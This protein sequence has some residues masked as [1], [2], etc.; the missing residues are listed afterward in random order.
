MTL[1]A[2]GSEL[3]LGCDSEAEASSR[4]PILSRD[5]ADLRKQF[6]A[7]N[8]TTSPADTSSKHT[9]RALARCRLVRHVCH[10]ITCTFL[11]DRC[12]FHRLWLL[13]KARQSTA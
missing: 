11:L 12:P 3:E 7:H 13:F 9:L 5:I 8:A 10:S 1:A 6:A 4:K 2:E